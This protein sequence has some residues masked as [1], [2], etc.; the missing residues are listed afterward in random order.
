VWVTR[1]DQLWFGGENTDR[2][3]VLPEKHA[4]EP[5]DTA[6][7]QVRMPFRQATAL[8]A[9][10]REGI[11]DTRV[12][13]LNGNDP[14]IELKVDPSWGPNVYVSVLALR[15]R[16]RDVPWYSFFTWG[17]KAPLEWARA[18]WYE[19][20][21]YEAP[22]ALVDLSK[23]AF[24]Y[25]LAEIKVGT[26]AHRLAV[27][28]TP[29]AKTYAVRGRAHVK[30]R[31]QMPGGKPA[32]VGTQIAVAAVD[33][34]LLE[35]M[36][37][38]SWNLLE[39]MLTR[40]EYGVETAT[41][42]MEIVGRR[43]FGRKAVPAGGGGGHA[44]NRELFDTLLLWNPRVTL[45]ANGEA[46][47]DVPLNDSLTSFRIVAI[48][49]VGSGTFGTGSTS[50]RSTQDLQLISGL[51]PLVREGDQF[52]AQFTLRNTTARAMK[53]VVDAKA[54]GLALPTQTV[55]LAAN[56]A[57]EIAWNVSAPDGLADSALPALTWTVGA[58][59]LGGP[60]ATDAL[61]ITQR[62]AAA[63]PV[64]VQQATL[65]QVDGTL[66][67]PVAA[68]P[69][70]SAIQSG[71][72]Q[73]AIRG[74]IAVSLQARLADGLPGV[75]RWLERYPYNCLEQQSSR[76]I[77]LRDLQMWQAVIA[78]MPVYLDRSGL[79]NYFP[80]GDDSRDSG[81]TTLSAYLLA[82]SD[83]AAQLDT[84]FA[85]PDD[86]RSK[87]EG[88]LIAFVEGRLER[89]PWAPRKDL[90]LRKLAALEA[91]SR[92]NAVEPRMLDSLEVAPNQWP[93]SAV[94]DYYAVL[95]RVKSIPQR[96]DKLAQIEQVLRARLTY[97]GTRLTF[98]TET[99]DD[100]WW[101]MT[102]PETN[103][104]RLALTFVDAPGWKDEM[105]RLVAGL[106]ALQHNGA[107]QTTTSNV[108]GSLAVERFSRAFE[109]EPVSGRTKL[110]LGTLERTIAWQDAA[111]DA[112]RAAPVAAASEAAAATSAGSA[113]GA[114]AA[115]PA[116]R[117]A[118]ARSLLLPWPPA[119]SGA[120]P[121]TL[122]LTQDGSGKPWA[123]IESLAA[124]AL[125][126]PFAAGYRITKTITPL[127][128]AVKGVYTRGDVVRVHLDID[129][130][131]D[132]TWVVVNDPVPAGATILGSGLGRDSEAATH[133]EKMPDGAWPSFVER[134]FDGYRAYYEFLPKGKFSVEYTARL[135]NVGTFGLPPTR[136]EALYAPSTYG[137]L[138]NAAV[139]VQP[140][141]GTQAAA[142]AAH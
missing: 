122:T 95:S 127:D 62:V 14:T 97:Q 31:V 113:A 77:G 134:G 106:L 1:A 51:P 88:G 52:R 40:R 18:F 89:K 38:D 116:T 126:A 10:E 21:S 92:F 83:E 108:W 99:D 56:S 23:P 124:I 68:P 46:A 39:A 66:S 2:I 69:E 140:A 121:L 25:G 50:I 135:N 8:V 129:A 29:D 11:I 4:Y 30:L 74:G 54:P 98:S 58:A 24:R 47:L 85:L 109:S 48:A 64:T 130:Q 93:T 13:Q 15:G 75:R 111:A 12:V 132:M 96:D 123:T 117:S 112:G 34:A 72:M 57:R 37:N 63:I 3:D 70:A 17:W 41:A 110:Q 141:S 115:T 125:K 136:V 114:A 27:T 65:A 73:G 26:A 84:R 118:A 131:T 133:D 55:E 128:P 87:L 6:R 20:R 81:S 53:V 33:E 43:H 139:V 35:L 78:K 86:L 19:G 103:A 79:A 16:I 67:M 102:G 60:H 119:Q 90:D 9:V 32:P 105:P 80:P 44:A 22:T 101:L 42:Q 71:P 91:L 100:L 138:P 142:S 45:D 137:V 5:G 120:Q 7:F 36:P 94:L 28:V 49:A 76:A 104:A 59:E 61:K 82:A 107:W